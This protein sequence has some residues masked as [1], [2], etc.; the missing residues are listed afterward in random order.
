ML[1]N[2]ALVTGNFNVL[3][4]GH[5]RLLKFAKSLAKKLIVGVFSDELAASAVDINEDLRVEA[6]Y[7]INLVDEVLLINTSLQDFLTTHKPDVVVK[8]KEFE[9]K[10]N[11]EQEIL[12]E[13]GGQLI[14]SS[15]EIG[16]STNTRSEKGLQLPDVTRDIINSFM[17]RHN[18][19]SQNLHN[20]VEKFNSKNICVIGDLIVDEYIDCFPI[21]MSQ[22]EPTLVVSPQNTQ[23]FLGGAGIV[24]SH[25]SSLGAKVKFLS[26]TGQMKY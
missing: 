26:V 7:S 2:V 1:D 17:A 20:V 13:Y 21:G 25:A 4:P 11:I 15:G 12:R 16:F 8:G 10:F 18:I 5:I 19:S 24:A 6:V 14:F 22:E 9:G 23:Q 3:H